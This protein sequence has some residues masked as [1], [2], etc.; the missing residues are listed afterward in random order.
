MK[1]PCKDC[2]VFIRCKQKLE[3]KH[4]NQVVKLSKSCILL[5]EY[6][7]K[8][9]SDSD[10]HVVLSRKIFG[11]QIKGNYLTGERLRKNLRYIKT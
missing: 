3:K 10:H 4:D 7:L 6:L 8:S 5:T 11:L 9:K 1:C 2:L